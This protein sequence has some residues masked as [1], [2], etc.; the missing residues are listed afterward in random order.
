MQSVK[1]SQ[2]QRPTLPEIAAVKR[3]L[4]SKEGRKKRRQEGNCRRQK[5][6]GNRVKATGWPGGGQDRNIK[7]IGPG[8]LGGRGSRGSNGR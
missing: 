5:E 8:G 4:G 3:W 7:L 1:A 6:K 2:I